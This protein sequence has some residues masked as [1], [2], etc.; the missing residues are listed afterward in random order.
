[1]RLFTRGHLDVL[2]SD[3]VNVTLATLDDVDPAE[4][5]AAPMQ[6]CDGRND[7]WHLAPAHCKHL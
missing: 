4:L 3:Y 1:V 2:G 5:A 6:F 7:A